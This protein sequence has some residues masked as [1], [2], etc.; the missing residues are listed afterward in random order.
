MKYQS[1]WLD[2]KIKNNIKELNKDKNV[3]VLIIGGGIT[4]L[5]TLY[6][7]KDSN[8]KVCLVEALQIGHGLSGRTTG[9]ITYLQELIYQNLT[10]KY[11]LNAA[12][13][14]LDSQ[15]EA[16]NKI[17]D[18]IKNENIKCNLDKTDSY[19]F[20]DKYKDINLIQKEKD[21]LSKLNVFVKEEYNDL[22]INSKYAIKIED[23]YVFNPIKYLK[24]LKNICIKSGKEI[25]ENTKIIDIKKNN[26]SYICKTNKY[27]IYTKKIVFACHYLPFLYPYFMPLKVR[28]EKSY[29][30]AYLENYKKYSL[31]TPKKPTKSIRFYNDVDSYKIYLTNSSL[32][33]NNI[34]E[35]RNYNNLLKNIN[36]KN[37]K[38]MWK[39]ED[40]LTID[41]LPYIGY[42]KNNNKDL[43]IG[44]GYNTW[45]MTNGTIAGSIISDMLLNKENKY[46]ELFN[47]L[48]LDIISNLPS[49]LLN[50]GCNLKFNICDNIYKIK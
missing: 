46:K 45:G 14:Y 41:K 1:I 44:T 4:G 35:K 27:K 19:I 36:N 20:T 32:I 22:D 49:Y 26:N 10:K 8:L 15:K 24:E 13:L 48:R 5:S 21:I 28:N 34:N 3:D 39:N 23:S 16:I 33:C 9:K 47:P 43:L 2:N 17:L 25:Y 11:N 42:L 12:K 29:I 38:Y 30:T 50:I 6:F 7:L 37:I 31:I 18:I 40:L